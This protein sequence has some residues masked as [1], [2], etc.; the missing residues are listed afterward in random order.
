MGVPREDVVLLV[1]RALDE[2]ADERL[3]VV[4]RGLDLVKQPEADVSR[5]LVVAR[6]ARVQLA[7]ERAN[8]LA[9]AA[10]VGGVDVL[11]VLLGRELRCGSGVL[12]RK[13]GGGRTTPSAHSLPTAARP[14]TMRASSAG[15]RMPTRV[16]DLAYAMEPRMSTA[17]M[18]WSYLS[19]WLKA[20][21]LRG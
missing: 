10:L 6:A 20:C 16:R 21:I 17:A 11:V 13:R 5:D 18:R 8:E 15:V 1:V 2:D 3:E 14:A 7:A 19:D 12:V 9:E 4:L